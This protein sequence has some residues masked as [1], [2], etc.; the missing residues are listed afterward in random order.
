M[1]PGRRVRIFEHAGRD[2]IAPVVP[3]VF[4][5]L[6]FEPRPFGVDKVVVRKR[7]VQ[8]RTHHAD[9]SAHKLGQQ[10]IIVADRD[11]KLTSRRSRQR[12]EISRHA[13]VALVALKSHPRVTAGRV[14]R[15]RKSL[16]QSA[17]VENEDLDVRN[18]SAPTLPRSPLADNEADRKSE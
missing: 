6:R 2:S 11:Q 17:I 12:I 1:A 7:H 16:V 13:Q 14:P 15:N 4:A 5:A 10:P 3:R 9:Q 18:K 8:L